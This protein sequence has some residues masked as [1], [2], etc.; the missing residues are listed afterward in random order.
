MKRYEMSW[1]IG[2]E[3]EGR[4]MKDFLK[5]HEISKRTLTAVKFA[6]GELSVNGRR[7]DVRFRL[8]TGDCLRV[9]FPV[10]DSSILP[11]P[12]PLEVLYEDDDVLVVHKPSGMKTIPSTDQAGG[13]LANAIRFHYIANGV[14]STVHIVTRLDKDTSGIVLVAKHRH[15]HHLFTLSQK[16]GNVSREYEAIAH[17]VFTDTEGVIEAPIGRKE[18]S[19][20]ERMV[21][22]DGRHA[23]TRYR[24][25]K[26][27][28]AY[29]HLRLQLETGR[30]HQI[31]VHLSHIGHPLEGDDLYGGALDRIKRQALHC[32]RLTFFHPVKQRELTFHCPLPQDMSRLVDQGS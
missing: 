15:I 2:E 5:D 9:I 22:E 16:Q 11:E 30:T 1:V 24:V 20:I 31:R 7:E 29:A 13:T 3:D 14:A 23:K 28:G 27:Y 18:T 21:R 25:E 6:G 4:L 10:E 26:Q 17:G 8:H 12:V 19:I 32:S